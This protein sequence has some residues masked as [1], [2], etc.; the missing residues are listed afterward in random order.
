[1][2]RDNNG[3]VVVIDDDNDNKDDEYCLPTE[4]TAFFAKDESH[5]QNE[6]ED[7][8]EGSY[9]AFANLND[10]EYQDDDQRL[11]SS[12]EEE[13][14][15][16]WETDYGD[17]STIDDVDDHD[18]NDS[19]NWMS[20]GNTSISSG[21]D[22]GLAP[23]FSPTSIMKVKVGATERAK[24]TLKSKLD[25]SIMTLSTASMTTES[26]S[27]C[28]Q[29]QNKSRN[30]K[31][32]FLSRGPIGMMEMLT[33]NTSSLNLALDSSQKEEEEEEEEDNE[34]SLPVDT[35]S[36][37]QETT[38]EEVSRSSA[39]EECKS[40]TR[41]I[42]HDETSTVPISVTNNRNAVV[43]D[44]KEEKPCNQI[45]KN[46]SSGRKMYNLIGKFEGRPNYKVNSDNSWIRPSSNRSN[47]SRVARKDNVDSL[48][49]I[50]ESRSSVRS[51]QSPNE[52]P[53]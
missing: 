32:S 45:A 21:G 20:Y 36:I 1:M 42:K 26:S 11:W 38:T 52:A 2:E 43:Y 5:E 15:N 49:R 19:A 10:Q 9:E 24:K 28:R 51:K 7:D 48:T 13:S 33:E 31:S 47:P 37:P 3:D 4:T 16:G 46:H 35:T 22:D 27:P 8:D 25:D 53:K 12:S 44:E 39:D 23:F 30:D 34:E 14:S 40:L 17:E 18:F 50:F 41:D 29:S 6:S